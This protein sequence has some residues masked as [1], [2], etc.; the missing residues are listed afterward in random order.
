MKSGVEVFQ[1]ADSLVDL[2]AR[3]KR[4]RD[5]VAAAMGSHN[6]GAHDRWIRQHAADEESLASINESVDELNFDYSNAPLHELERAITD[7][8]ALRTIV[9]SITEKYVD[10]IAED[11]RNREF[12][13]DQAH[14]RV[15]RWLKF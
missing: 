9:G 1:S 15:N 7:V 12:I 10:S 4:S 3:A 11:D 14:A 6:S 2:L 8:H 13:R 5:A